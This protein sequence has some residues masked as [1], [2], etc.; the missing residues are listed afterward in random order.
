[1]SHLRP[2][3]PPNIALTDGDGLTNGETTDEAP[4]LISASATASIAGGGGWMDAEEEGGRP[5]WG[6]AE[7]QR[8]NEEA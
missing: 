7:E 5:S 2:P 6:R 8:M 1:M 4:F 3:P